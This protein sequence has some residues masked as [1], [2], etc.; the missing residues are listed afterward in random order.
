MAAMQPTNIDTCTSQLTHAWHSILCLKQILR[1]PR[2]VLLTQAST[3]QKS[4]VTGS[5]TTQE[6]L[7]PI[8]MQHVAKRSYGL[9]LNLAAYAELSLAIFL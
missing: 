9:C 4:V 1:P 6:S 8:A 2:T 3:L 7:S 5:D